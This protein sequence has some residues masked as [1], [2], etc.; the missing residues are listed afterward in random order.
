[1]PKIAES[2]R[3]QASLLPKWIQPRISKKVDGLEIGFAVPP[4]PGEVLPGSA[5]QSDGGALIE[6]QALGAE[7]REAQP[8]T[9]KRDERQ[10]QPRWRVRFSGES[11][12]Q[13]PELASGSALATGMKTSRGDRL[14]KKK[15]RSL[16]QPRQ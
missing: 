7:V 1:M 6:P 2:E 15:A 8:R 16:Y 9:G 11:V 14:S 12:A 4:Y 13:T 3:I 10:N 5:C